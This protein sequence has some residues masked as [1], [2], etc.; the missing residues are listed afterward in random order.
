MINLYWCIGAQISHKIKNAEWGSGVVKELAAHIRRN[1]PLAKGFS[2]KNLWRM[3]QFVEVYQDDPKLSPLVREL[4]WA[5]N[6]VIFSRCKTPEER[7]FY[8]HLT[9]KERYSKR[10]LDRQISSG[11]FE[12]TLIGQATGHRPADRSG[13]EKI[14]LFKDHYVFE[15]L[16]LPEPHT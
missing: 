9:R 8:L 6:L 1:E 7:E 14:H 2:D 3:K 16:N 11:L 4:S 15:F 12:R 13:S 5:Q 10:E